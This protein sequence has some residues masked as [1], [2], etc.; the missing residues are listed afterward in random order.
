MRKQR[1]SKFVGKEFDNGWVCTGIN[2]AHATLTHKNGGP[3]YWYSMERR[4]SDG[5]FDKW[6]RLEA[7]EATKVW[8]GLIT[9]EEICTLR[10]EGK[11]KKRHGHSI[12]YNFR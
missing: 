7:F 1:T 5:K 8:K 3:T 12:N 9:V 10:E 11:A 6:I 2:I 4:T